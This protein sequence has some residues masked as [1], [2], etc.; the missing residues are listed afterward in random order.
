[1]ALYIEL[2]LASYVQHFQVVGITPF[3]PQ[4]CFTR[5]QVCGSHE[6]FMMRSETIMG[7]AMMHIGAI[8]QN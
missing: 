5:S 8:A 3:G 4:E 1:M 6:E 7:G 2:K